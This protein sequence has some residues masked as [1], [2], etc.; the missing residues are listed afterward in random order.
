MILK[1]LHYVPVEAATAIIGA[2]GDGRTQLFKLFDVIQQALMATTIDQVQVL[3]SDCR[4]VLRSPQGVAQGDM[5][6][7]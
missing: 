5:E 4:T 2:S 3:G 1:S 7:C 6:G